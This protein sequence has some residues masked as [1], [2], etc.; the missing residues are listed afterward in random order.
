MRSSRW[1]SESRQIN[2]FIASPSDLPAERHAFRDAIDIL[3]AGFGD[4]ANVEFVPL[5]WEEG[6]GRTCVPS[7]LPTL[8]GGECRACLGGLWFSHVSA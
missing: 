4:G 3:N 7:V 1:S 2:V 6:R 5:G 8:A